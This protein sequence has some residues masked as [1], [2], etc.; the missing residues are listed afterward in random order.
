MD[1]IIHGIHQV[2]S[3]YWNFG[4]KKN[5]CHFLK[6]QI[7]LNHAFVKIKTCYILDI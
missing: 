7:T 2:K 5:A 4:E 1:T 3:L 6:L